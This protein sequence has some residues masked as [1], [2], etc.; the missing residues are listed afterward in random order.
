VEED[1]FARRCP[2]AY[3]TVDGLITGPYRL[4]EPTGLRWRGSANQ[5]LV[6]LTPLGMRRY[7]D[8]GDSA[9]AVQVQ[10]D[11]DGLWLIGVPRRGDLA[12][13]ERSLAARGVR[14]DGVSWRP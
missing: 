5:R 1:E 11:D 4:D 12:R 8:P 14:L 7:A 9:P 10:V 3:S 2:G 6:A 13:L